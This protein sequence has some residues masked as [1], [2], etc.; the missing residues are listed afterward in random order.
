MYKSSLEKLLAEGVA[1]LKGLKVSSV[2]C[3]PGDK[4]M[5]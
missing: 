1:V 2:D 5:F 3:R 4:L